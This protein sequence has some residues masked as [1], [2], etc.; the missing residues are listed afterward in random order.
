MSQLIETEILGLQANLD[1]AYIPINVQ[2]KI[3]QRFFTRTNQ[4]QEE[5]VLNFSKM[6]LGQLVHI[7]GSVFSMFLKFFI[8]F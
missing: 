3:F 4:T 1:A 7:A 8:F 6:G 2:E 5:Q